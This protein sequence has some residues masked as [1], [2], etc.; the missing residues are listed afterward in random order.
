M[1]ARTTIA[2]VPRETFSQ[3]VRSLDSILAAT[4]GA[5][6]LV[7]VDAGSPRAVASGL[8][9]RARRHDALLIRCDHLMSPNQA[10]NLALRYVD[11]EFV[12]FVDNDLLVRTG[13]LR[14]LES[15][16]LATGA[17]FVGPLYTI[18]ES[19]EV[20]HGAGGECSVVED[21]GTRRFRDFNP[22][23]GEPLAHVEASVRRQQCGR[24]EFHAVLARRDVL[25]R[26][27]PFDEGLL[28][29]NE[30]CD[31]A[32]LV[33]DH[34]GSIWFEPDAV[35][36]YAPQRFLSWSDLLFYVVRWSDEWTSRSLTRFAEKWRLPDDDPALERVGRYGARHR[37]L[38]YHPYRSPFGRL[39]A[40]RGRVPHPIIDRV[41]QPLALRR[42]ERLLAASTGPRL[43]HVPS[44][45]SREA[46]GVGAP[47]TNLQL[48]NRPAGHE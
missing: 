21:G 48:F 12:A 43:L 31:A 32:M 22:G 42:H 45:M 19:F 20:V 24:F 16:A 3:S 34:G 14:R 40:R 39:A 27:G 2:V 44:W 10:R 35:V 13:W 37:L 47:Q 23:A 5:Y 4:D 18:G 15:C 11:T 9:A 29:V 7:Y 8:E 41:V 26:L 6:R 33:H 25:E 30:H 28:S 38:A 17:W 1:K 46:A 36:T